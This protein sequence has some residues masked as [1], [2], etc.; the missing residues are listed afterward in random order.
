MGS[1]LMGEVINSGKRVCIEEAGSI[2]VMWRSL[3]TSG[4]RLDSGSYPAV[5]GGPWHLAI[6]AS[7]IRINKETPSHR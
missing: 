6:G 3:V 4:R 2:P 7:S 5:V 1:G